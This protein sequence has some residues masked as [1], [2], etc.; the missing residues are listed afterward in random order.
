MSGGDFSAV[1]RAEQD[2]SKALHELPDGYTVVP[3]PSAV[4][5]ENPDMPY[6]YEPDFL[7]SDP[8]GRTLVV[9]VKMPQSM[10]WSNMARFVQ[11][12]RQ[13]RNAG[14]AFLVL[15]PGAQA[16]RASAPTAE[17]DEVNVAYGKDEPS[18]VQAVIEA[19]RQAPS[20]KEQP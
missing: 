17:F 11:I 5:I 18:L 1:A 6:R 14:W 2:V 7:V 9:E 19:L 10:S 20:P 4:T 16:Q 15:V 8:A 13:V 3:R 12:D